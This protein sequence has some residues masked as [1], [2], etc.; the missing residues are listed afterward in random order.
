MKYIIT[1]RKFKSICDDL[2]NHSD[3][4]QECCCNYDNDDN[5][6]KEK[7]CPVVKS[8]KKVIK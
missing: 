7:F 5:E 4:L 1:F 3:T 6:C 8:L 2:G